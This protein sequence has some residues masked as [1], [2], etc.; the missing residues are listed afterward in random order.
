MRFADKSA[1]NLVIIFN[2]KNLFVGAVQLNIFVLHIV[3]LSRGRI[4]R[5]SSQH[6]CMA[7]V[8]SPACG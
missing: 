2:L 4:Y 1:G 3:F 8:L 6:A 7:T 5:V